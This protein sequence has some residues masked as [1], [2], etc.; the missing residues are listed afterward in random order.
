MSFLKEFK[1]FA[2]KGSVIDLAV[3]VII[4]GAFS[5]IVSS[6][7]EDIIMPFISV[8]LGD[9]DFSSYGLVLKEAQDGQA[10]IVLNYGTFIQ[11][12][13]YFIIMAFVIFLMVKAINKI[14][15][16]D[17]AEEETA[18]SQEELLTEIRDLLKEQNR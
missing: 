18:P 4:G 3:G 8:L 7:A 17:A 16:T 1:E 10:A 2:M 13:I 9:M 5:K 6:L 11:N 14:R 15:R 12:I